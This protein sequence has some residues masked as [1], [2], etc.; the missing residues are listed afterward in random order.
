MCHDTPPIPPLV[1]RSF[2]VIATDIIQLFYLQTWVDADED[3]VVD[4]L[5]RTETA[6]AT[7]LQDM[8]PWFDQPVTTD[9]TDPNLLANAGIQ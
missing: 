7:W 8:M 5:D 9:S 3:G 2:P 4:D 6:M 1:C